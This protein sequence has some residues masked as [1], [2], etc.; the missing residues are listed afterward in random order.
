[1]VVWLWLGVVVVRCVL[2]VVCLLVNVVVRCL[3][4]VVCCSKIMGRC[5]VLLL[6]VFAVGCLLSLFD[7][8]WLRFAVCRCW[9]W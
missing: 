5:G 9:T 1:M 4:C 7:G 8:G 3:M 6:R 2:R